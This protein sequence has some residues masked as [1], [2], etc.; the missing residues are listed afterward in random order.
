MS[1][2]PVNMWVS[3]GSN[4]AKLRNLIVVALDS[5][6][7][8][9]NVCRKSPSNFRLHAESN[10]FNQKLCL[11]QANSW[12]NLSNKE[13][14]LRNFVLVVYDCGKESR[15]NMCRKL[16]SNYSISVYKRK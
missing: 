7:F 2:V 3:F 12:V 6:R 9:R 14:K 8:C 10:H 16:P 1:T 5:G 11:E 4:K 13:A 15:T